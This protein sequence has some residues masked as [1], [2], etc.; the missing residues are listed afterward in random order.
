M[1]KN[2]GLSKVPVADKIGNRS[3]LGYHIF[4]TFRCFQKV[5]STLNPTSSFFPDVFL[6][7][8]YRNF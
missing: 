5:S 3:I 2:N 7:S 1:K 6:V 4:K 8:V